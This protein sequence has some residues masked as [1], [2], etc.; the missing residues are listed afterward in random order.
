M[1]KASL[2]TYIGFKKCFS[3]KFYLRFSSGFGVKT[4]A[5][6]L[7]LQRHRML[8]TAQPCLAV[9]ALAAG[10]LLDKLWTSCPMATLPFTW[11]HLSALFGFSSRAHPV[12]MMDARVSEIRRLFIRLLRG[13]AEILCLWV[14]VI[15]LGITEITAPTSSKLPRPG[16]GSVSMKAPEAPRAAPLLTLGKGKEP[17]SLPPRKRCP[18]ER[19]FS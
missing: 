7:L 6:S 19:S 5:I 15:C 16:K 4:R 8:R 2:S 3:V 14:R 11:G 10:G 12:V 13:W 17:S 18:Q 1:N 9:L